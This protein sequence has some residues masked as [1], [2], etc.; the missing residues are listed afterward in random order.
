[1][2]TTKK[3]ATKKVAAKTKPSGVECRVLGHHA[4]DRVQPGGTVFVDQ[5]RADRFCA[6]GTLERVTPP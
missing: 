2:T 3:A 6:A 4:I 5:A 1:M